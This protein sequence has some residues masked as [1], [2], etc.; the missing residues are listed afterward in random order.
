MFNF[1]IYCHHSHGSRYRVEDLKL[2]GSCGFTVFSDKEV[3]DNQVKPECNKSLHI[4][5]HHKHVFANWIRS[6]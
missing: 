4:H 1:I 5:I 3:K 6:V 2:K